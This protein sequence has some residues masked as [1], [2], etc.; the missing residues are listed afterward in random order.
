MICTSNL[1]EMTTICARLYEEGAKFEANR[2]NGQWEIKL[3]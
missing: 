1:E 3:T 2:V